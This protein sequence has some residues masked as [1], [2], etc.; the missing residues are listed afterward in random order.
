MNIALAADN[1]YSKYLTISVV[2][3]MESNKNT[4]ITFYI[5]DNGIELREKQYLCNKVLEYGQTINFIC[6]N[7]LVGNIKV[8]NTFPIATYSRLFL[9]RIKDIDRIIYFDC[10]SLIVDDLQELWSIEM[11][12]ELFAGVYDPVASYYKKHIGLEKNS[13]Y[14]NS[15]VLLMNLSELRK[16]NWEEKVLAFIE[17]F[18]GS[19]P[20][21]DQGIVNGLAKNR[22]KII[23]PRYNAMDVYFV[24]TYKQMGKLMSMKLPYSEDIY[25][26]A[27]KSPVFI[28]FTAGFFGRVWDVKCRHPKKDLYKDM[29]KLAGYKEKEVMIDK[30]QNRNAVIMQKIYEI[31]PFCIYCFITRIIDIRKKYVRKINIHNRRLENE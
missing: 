21:H 2:S 22:I 3:I 28:H 5:I 8:D 15:G 11:S 6:S 14:I 30:P 12:D 4:D 10:D 18:N 13:L 16:F 25:D 9:C 7:Q 19:I 1:N 29:I 31:L 27:R 24:Y 23:S 20:H 26:E 17:T